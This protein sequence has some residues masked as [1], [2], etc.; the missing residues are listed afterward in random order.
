VPTV[1]HTFLTSVQLAY[2]CHPNHG[3][4]EGL[5]GTTDCWGSQRWFLVPI[6]S[7]KSMRSENTKY[8]N[9]SPKRHCYSISQMKHYH[10]S[11]VLSKQ[12]TLSTAECCCWMNRVPQ[13]AVVV[14]DRGP[15]VC[16]MLDWYP[17]SVCDAITAP[18][19]SDTDAAVVMSSIMLQQLLSSATST[20]SSRTRN[21]RRLGP[22]EHRQAAT[23]ISKIFDLKVIYVSILFN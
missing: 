13:V 17:V 10:R 21:W 19:C 22:A 12:S 8:L 16:M 4:S 7:A 3:L 9:G 14:V 5:L 2:S 18:C 15:V 1:P 23:K 11:S 20:M 6:T